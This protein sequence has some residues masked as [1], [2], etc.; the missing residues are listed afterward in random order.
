M[1]QTSEI[2]FSVYCPALSK[3]VILLK[4]TWFGHIIKAHGSL[5][6]KEGLLKR[7]IEK[8]DKPHRFLRFAD[9]PKN[10]W[11]IDHQCPDFK[12]YH[13]CLRIAFKLLE[14]SS[15]IVASAY[16]IERGIMTYGT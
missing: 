10:F 4:N 12:P 7:V 5:R 8:V 2:L 3:D 13:E 14:D 16:P 9:E 1:Q 11:F 6:S 15:V